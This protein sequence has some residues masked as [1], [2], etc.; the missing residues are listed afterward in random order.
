MTKIKKHP[1]RDQYIF[2]MIGQYYISSVLY[3]YIVIPLL[4]LNFLTFLPSYS[5]LQFFIERASRFFLF[6]FLKLHVYC[7]SSSLFQFSYFL[8]LIQNIILLNT[9]NFSSSGLL[10]SPLIPSLFLSLFLFHLLA[11]FFSFPFFFVFFFLL[12]IPLFL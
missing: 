10:V 8:T 9:C 1:Y 11:I 2:N 4:F 12:H 7:N 5:R 6:F 3:S